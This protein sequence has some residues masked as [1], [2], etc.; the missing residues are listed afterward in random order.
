M[1]CCDAELHRLR[2]EALTQSSR[3]ASDRSAAARS[4]DLAEA[5]FWAGISVARQQSAQ[6][7]E[8]RITLSLA[9]LLLEA[10]RDAEAKQTLAL[11]C[12]AFDSSAGT[13]DLAAARGLLDHSSPQTPRA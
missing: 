3:T 13:P 1:R 11:I 2:S 10:G 6:T 8:L 5:S 7:L 9:R 4:R 12:E